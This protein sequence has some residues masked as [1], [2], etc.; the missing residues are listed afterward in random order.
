MLAAA[1][2]AFCVALFW[3]LALIINRLVP[4]TVAN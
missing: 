2:G 3:S 1:A 4:R